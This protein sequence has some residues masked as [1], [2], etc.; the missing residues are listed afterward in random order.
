MRDALL[1]A[2]LFS[3]IG[4]NAQT[5]PL[6][7]RTA[8]FPD[9]ERSWTADVDT[10]GMTRALADGEV[11]YL[12]HVLMTLDAQSVDSVSVDRDPYT[13]SPTLSVRLSEGAAESFR[14]I[15][16]AR[17]GEAIAI[18]QG[19]RVLTAPTLIEAI[20]NGRIS[21]TGQFSRAELDG[22]AET[23]RG[24]SGAVDGRVG[25][26]ERLRAGLDLTTPEGAAA[27]FVGAMRAGDWPTAAHALHPTSLRV[28]RE[29]GEERLRLDGDRV[30]TLD[31]GAL[32]P[33]PRMEGEHA[34][35]EPE[36]RL[37]RDALGGP[38]PG[39]TWAD[40]SDEQV[41]VLVFD[42]LGGPGSYTSADVV[43]AVAAGPDAAYVV[44]VPSGPAAVDLEG[45]TTASVMK[46][47]R[48]GSEWR[49]LL[50]TVD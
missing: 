30:W 29:E 24:A 34:S 49:V 11:V 5:A 38:S 12:G 10:A 14:E 50:P 43:G 39:S 28:V 45:V 25:E 13:G 41:V 48:V 16:S 6:E 4:A 36:G 22:I 1:L 26:I 37:V 46:A 7:L 42:L 8:F 32:P 23:L 31:R 18:V 44:L 21:I 47:L 35:P 3:S 19:T 15:T 40:F 17:V 9:R 20:P 2:A 33:A 27:A